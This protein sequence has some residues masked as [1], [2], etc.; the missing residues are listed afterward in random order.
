MKPI[1]NIVIQ[2]TCDSFLSGNM[3]EGK[4][5]ANHVFPVS[6]VGIFY[7]GSAVLAL[8]SLHHQ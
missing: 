3:S 8:H 5:V 1:K 4:V 6:S 2:Y 7:L